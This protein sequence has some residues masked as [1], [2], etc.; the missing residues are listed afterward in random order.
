M[1][2]GQRARAGRG[3]QRGLVDLQADPVPEGCTNCSPR[4]AAVDHRAGRGVHVGRPRCRARA[5]PGRPPGPPRPARTARAA[6]P[7]PG[8]ARRCGSC[9]SGSRRPARR[10]PWS[11][12]RRGAARRRSGRWCGTAEFAPAATIVSNAGPAAPWPRIRSSRS[13]ATSRSVRPGRSPPAASRSASA[14][15]AAAQAARSAAISASSLT[16]RSRCTRPGARCRATPGGRLGQRV[17]GVHGDVVGL[18]AQR[19]HA[20]A[21]RR[22]RRARGRCPRPRSRS[23]VGHLAARPGCG[24]G[25]RCRTGWRRRRRRAPAARRSSR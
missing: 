9:P 8:R 5:P 7:R 1:P 16:M 12:G 13:R 3:E 15:S 20:R 23:Q 19:A 21:R 6:S 18:E 10:S 17:V 11:P 2:G 22:P 4:P 24:S 25:R 14:A